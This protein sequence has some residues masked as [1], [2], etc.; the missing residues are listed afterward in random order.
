MSY[1]EN[2]SGKYD[3]LMK[4]QIDVY[5]KE[6]SASYEKFSLHKPE[7][8]DVPKN[9]SAILNYIKKRTGVETVGEAMNHIAN[10]NIP[11]NVIDFWI[12]EGM[13]SMPLEKVA[14]AHGYPEY[15]SALGVSQKSG[16]DA[17]YHA[18]P[19]DGDFGSDT[20]LMLNKYIFW[21]SPGRVHEISDS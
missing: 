13:C 19:E 8:S 3:F 16:H 1:N 9:R 5:I 17:V 4:K 18:V 12:D 14:I 6:L 21:L 2:V 10:G 11:R 15:A 20:A 7:L